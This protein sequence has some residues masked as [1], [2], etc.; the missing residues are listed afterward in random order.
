MS[1]LL[2][3]KSLVL[4]PGLLLISSLEP[5]L[6]FLWNPFCSRFVAVPQNR[7]FKWNDFFG[8]RVQEMSEIRNF[9]RRKQ[10]GV[11][12]NVFLLFNFLFL[13]FCMLS[14]FFFFLIFFSYFKFFVSCS[15]DWVFFSIFDGA[16]RL[17]IRIVK[18]ARESYFWFSLFFYFW[19]SLN[20]DS[21]ESF[22]DFCWS[23][24]HLPPPSL[25]CFR[26]KIFIE[27]TTCIYA[28]WFINDYFPACNNRIG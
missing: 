11:I 9:Q 8:G 26:S 14:L 2:M 10:H 7:Y 16:E 4:I 15:Q 27:K 13:V 1:R 25:F 6:K 19:C 12:A 22:L 28:S 20:Y 24:E 17:A 3:Q 23:P 5:K 21:S 18:F